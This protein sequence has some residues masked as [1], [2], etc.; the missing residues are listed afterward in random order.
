MKTKMKEGLDGQGRTIV[1]L[2]PGVIALKQERVATLN[3]LNELHR[4]LEA[5]RVN[6]AIGYYGCCAEFHRF[7]TSAITAY[8]R[9]RG[10]KDIDVRVVG[11]HVKSSRSGCKRYQVVFRHNAGAVESLIVSEHCMFNIEPVSKEERIYQPYK[12]A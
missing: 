9:H 5:E 1:M 4:N 12:A 10:P 8:E 7:V 3:D 2:L 6:N 11:R